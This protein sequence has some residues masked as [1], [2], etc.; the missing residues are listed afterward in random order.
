MYFFLLSFWDMLYHENY[1]FK[2]FLLLFE[3]MI[4][5]TTKQDKHS[6]KSP[7]GYICIVVRCYMS[8]FLTPFST[9]TLMN[10]ARIIFEFIVNR[11]DRCRS[12]NP[13]ASTICRQPTDTWRLKNVDFDHTFYSFTTILKCMKFI[14]SALFIYQILILVY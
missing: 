14:M 6:L 7:Y 4:N 2:K 11:W 1:F 13:S 12:Q 9:H 10:H 5:G 3:K 8:Y